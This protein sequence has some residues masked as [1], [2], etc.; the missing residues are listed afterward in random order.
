MEASPHLLVLQATSAEKDI[1]RNTVDV[2]TPAESTTGGVCECGTP[3]P[4][5]PQSETLTSFT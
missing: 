2:E 5:R 1:G 4:V 3:A